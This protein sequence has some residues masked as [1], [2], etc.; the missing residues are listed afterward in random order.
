MISIKK[1]KRFISPLMTSA[2]MDTEERHSLIREIG[3][4]IVT[5]DEF[6]HLLETKYPP[7][8]YDGFEPLR[9]VQIARKR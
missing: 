6:W 2:A 7:I 3:E 4:E 9:I 8:A 5:V 1:T